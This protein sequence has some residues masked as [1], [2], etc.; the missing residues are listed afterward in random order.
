VMA[1]IKESKY[2]EEQE[3]RTLPTVVVCAAHSSGLGSAMVG[4]HLLL[5]PAR[6]AAAPCCC[7]SPVPLLHTA[8]AR[9]PRCCSPAPLL[10][11]RCSTRPAAFAAARRPAA[12]DL[13]AAV[14]DHGH[15][16][17]RPAAAQAPA[18]AQPPPPPPTQSRTSWMGEG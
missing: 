8:A 7:Y 3:I 16:S 11:A 10:L 17:R 9:P 18:L 15:R 2:G 14:L 1:R 4:R 13:P 5:L 12:A 6:P